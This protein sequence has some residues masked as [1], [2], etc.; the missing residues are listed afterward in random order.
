MHFFF[1][2]FR[3]VHAFRS[4]TTGPITVVKVCAIHCLRTSHGSILSK[5]VGWGTSNCIGVVEPVGSRGGSKFNEGMSQLNKETNKK[6]RVYICFGFYAFHCFFN[7]KFSY[8]C[9]CY[10]FLQLMRRRLNWLL[11]TKLQ[12]RIVHFR[13]ARNFFVEDGSIPSLYSCTIW[14]FFSLGKLSMAHPFFPAVY[15]TEVTLRVV[16]LILNE[17]S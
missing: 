11:C 1:G 4:L 16:S 8:R 12:N 5:P 14:I 15:H 3:R 9:H 10:A 7:T 17:F 13:P 6:H 2:C